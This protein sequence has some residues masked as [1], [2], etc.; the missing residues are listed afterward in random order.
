MA[1]H[2]PEG[3]LTWYKGTILPYASLWHTLIRLGSLNRL[4]FSQLPDNPADS[5]GWRI[6]RA[7]WYPLFNE[8]NNVDINLILTALG[9]SPGTMRWSH[10]GGLAPWLQSIFTNHLRFCQTCLSQGYHSSFYSLKLLDACPIH[11][12]PLFDHCKCGAYVNSRQKSNNFRQYGKCYCTK[13][14]YIDS[15]CCRRPKITVEQT[16]TLDN[17]A[18]WLEELNQLIKPEEFTRKSDYS[19]YVNPVRLDVAGWCNALEID[20]PDQLIKSAPHG[21]TFAF[22]KGGPFLET[23]PKTKSDFNERPDKYWWEDS[24]ATWTYRSICRHLRRHVLKE[25]PRLLRNYSTPHD[26]TADFKKFIQEPKFAAAYAESEW[27]KHFDQNARMRRWPYRDPW[28]DPNQKFI[29]QLEVF[30]RPN[31]SNH[32]KISESIK[33]WLEYHWAAYCMLCIWTYYQDRT[34]QV[35]SSGN[36]WRWDKSNNLPSWDWVARVQSDGSVLFSCLKSRVP[37]LPV[38]HHKSKSERIYDQK[39]LEL[40]RAKSVVDACK[41]PCLNWSQRDGWSVTPASAPDTLD[42]K[43]LTLRGRFTERPKFWIFPANG[44]YVAR[45]ETV[46]LQAEEQSSR[47]AISSLRTAYKQYINRY[48]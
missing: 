14:I 3:G 1:R 21:H 27:A 46:A 42:Y 38:R 2:I 12:E 31:W 26:H 45:L 28:A 5:K 25:E 11:G 9:E 30:G 23:T 48:T 13:T 43:R 35:V 34:D 10:L 44:R 40:Q 39:I 7:N 20:Y 16:R 4:S 41:G 6:V 36:P 8:R 33:T 19:D 18:S 37:I 29:G 32:P 15:E 24:P 17:I 47:E 22:E